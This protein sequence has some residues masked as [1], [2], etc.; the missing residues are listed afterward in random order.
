MLR[1]RENDVRENEMRNM[2]V[3]D[4]MSK[5]VGLSLTSHIRHYHKVYELYLQNVRF[6]VILNGLTWHNRD[7]VEVQAGPS[8]YSVH[9][10][11][12]YEVWT[13]FRKMEIAQVI[14]REMIKAWY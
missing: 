14:F 8:E 1:D 4:I 7:F 5:S 6:E 13:N 10:L 9:P 3:Y 11:L 12:A 2:T